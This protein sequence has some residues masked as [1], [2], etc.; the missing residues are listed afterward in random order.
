MG[1]RQA[2][3][4]ETLSTFFI[5]EVPLFLFCL[6][7]KQSTARGHDLTVL[8]RHDTHLCLMFFAHL[9]ILRV[10]TLRAHSTVYVN[11]H[12]CKRVVV[13]NLKLIQVFSYLLQ[14]KKMSY[15]DCKSVAN[16]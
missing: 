9:I 2:T 14:V 3:V 1:L 8:K 7:T 15:E 13:I 11:T 6:R 4:S 16:K 5:D 12:V 10:H